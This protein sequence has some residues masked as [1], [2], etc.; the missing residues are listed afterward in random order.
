M[1]VRCGVYDIYWI[2][3]SY[4][5]WLKIDKIIGDFYGLN[6]VGLFNE[7]LIFGGCIIRVVFGLFR[8]FFCYWEFVSICVMGKVGF[9]WVYVILLLNGWNIV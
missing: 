2:G 8:G 4:F 1:L 6:R 3:W 5:E 7:V 9:G